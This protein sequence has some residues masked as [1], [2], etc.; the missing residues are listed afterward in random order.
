[1]MVLCI[2][3]AV[4]AVAGWVLAWC[5]WRVGL[6]LQRLYDAACKQSRENARAAIEAGDGWEKSLQRERR[7]LL[8]FW[9]CWCF[10]VWCWWRL[11]KRG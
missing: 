3:L 5:A 7:G 10:A 1:M 8:A 2:V 4:V 11:C 9:L 6:D